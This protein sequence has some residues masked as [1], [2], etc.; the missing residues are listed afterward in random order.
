M[1]PLSWFMLVLMI[2]L[3]GISQG[4]HIAFGFDVDG[5][6]TLLRSILALLR[7]CVGDFD[8]EPTNLPTELP[9]PLQ[10]SVNFRL[11]H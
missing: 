4:F 3:T 8:C 5:Y 7:M 10:P 1:K 11:L 9:P 6:Q 2:V